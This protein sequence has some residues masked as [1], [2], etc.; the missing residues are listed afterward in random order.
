MD[1]KCSAVCGSGKPGSVRRIGDA[2]IEPLVG[3]TQRS[4]TYMQ[5]EGPM[6][7]FCY[8]GTV[9]CE[10]HGEAGSKIVYTLVYDHSSMDE[11]RRVTE[12]ERLTA[13]FGSAVDTMRAAV[14]A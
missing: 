9:A 5:T 6:A 14:M 8:H 13:R 4:Y 12:K 3:A 2:I 1:V 10:P 7:S 11:D